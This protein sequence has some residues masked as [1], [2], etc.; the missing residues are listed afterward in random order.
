MKFL[1]IV[2]LVQITHDFLFYFFVIKPYPRLQNK[3]IDEFKSYAKYY[4]SQAVAADSLIYLITT[5]LLYFY[6]KKNKE[7]TNIFIS[8]VSIYLMGYFIH[9]KPV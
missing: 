3:V 6:L 2:L 4:Q 1:G 9:Q 5:P 7:E 8:I